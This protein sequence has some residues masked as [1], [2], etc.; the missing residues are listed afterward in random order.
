VVLS[1]P[2]FGQGTFATQSPITCP[3]RHIQPER[4]MNVTI[5]VTAENGTTGNNKFGITREIPFFDFED[6]YNG[7]IH[8]F[9]DVFSIDNNEFHAGDTSNFVWIDRRNGKYQ[10]LPS[11]IKESH[12]G[13]ITGMRGTKNN[14]DKID[15]PRILY[16]VSP[17]YFIWDYMWE[18]Y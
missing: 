14:G 10:I 2:Q 7:D 18:N 8:E 9:R 6:T 17:K 4:Y 15:L 1:P 3:N 16:I 5:K 11:V 12:I 13:S